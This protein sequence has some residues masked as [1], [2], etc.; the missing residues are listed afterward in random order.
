MPLQALSLR[1]G[2]A[3][4]LATA[5]AGYGL[6]VGGASASNHSD[7]PLSKQDPQTNL[8][9]VYAFVGLKYDDPGQKV[10]N[11]VINVRPFCEPGD[12]VIYDRF[13]DDARY[14]IHLTHPVSGAEQARYDFQFSPVDQ[15]IKNPATVL[16][17]GLGLE[18]GPIQDIGDNRQNYVQTYSVTKVVGATTTQIG[19]N[20]PVPPPNVGR[21]VTPFYNNERGLVASGATTFAELDVYTQQ[22]IQDLSDGA[23]AFAG[24]RDDSFFSDI[25]GIFDLLDLRILDNNGTLADGL[26]QDD[27]GVD[28][29]KGFNVLTFALQIPIGQLTPATYDT[30]FFG[31]QSGVGVYASTSRQSVRFIAAD[32]SRISIGPWVQV[33]R[34]GNPLFNEG[35]VALQ[36]KDRY[37][38]ANPVD[39]AQFATYAENPELAT[40]INFVYSTSFVE[41]G[42]S[43]LRA[44]FIPDV[45][46]V[47][48]TTDAVPLDGAAAF[49]RLGFIGGDTTN[50]V[51]SGWPNGRRLGDDVVDIA[52]TAIASGP[53]YSSIT[54]VGDNVPSNDV[55]Y[56]QVFPYAGTPQAGSR[57]R[58][59][60]F[61][62]DVDQ[63]GDVD[64]RDL[65]FVLSS[66]G[67]LTP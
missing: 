60:P 62:A 11:I 7:S 15:N 3:G 47:V 39:D 38:R 48:T 1:G 31:S 10:L 32:G 17:Y 20:L 8:T 55:A 14:S 52:L 16:S 13:S 29:F 40:L 37:N 30:V 18:A 63:D 54:V 67:T 35:L 49:N 19:A 2:S 27:G 50:G 44:I 64:I 26:G 45:L 22:A 58:K 23:V 4:R 46:R 25:P 65:G 5:L 61:Y 34:L 6:L 9:D 21:N 33:Q 59:D 12:G 28:G 57:N 24:M 43:D 56:H 66:F 53:S 41:S 42:R 51:S 36:D